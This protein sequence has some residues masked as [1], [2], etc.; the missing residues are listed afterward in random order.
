MM[1]CREYGF[2]RKWAKWDARL[3]DDN[4]K[5]L[6]SSLLVFLSFSLCWFFPISSSTLIHFHISISLTRSR[7]WNKPTHFWTLALLAYL[8]TFTHL[9]CSVE[10]CRFNRTVTHILHAICFDRLQIKKVSYSWTMTKKNV[11]LC[12]KFFPQ[13]VEPNYSFGV[14]STMM[15]QVKTCSIN[16]LVFLM[17]VCANMINV[18]IKWMNEWKKKD[19]NDRHPC[20][21]SIMIIDEPI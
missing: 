12:T 7:A 18:S 9:W 14:W 16:L 2:K 3:D 21:S 13:L 1:G 10:C 20:P 11:C 5:R 19:F 8:F 6:D 15:Y 4:E 17:C